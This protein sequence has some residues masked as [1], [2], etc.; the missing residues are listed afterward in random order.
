MKDKLLLV[1]ILITVFFL[2]I[3]VGVAIYIFYNPTYDQSKL[4]F[5]KNLPIASRFFSRNVMFL[6]TSGTEYQIGDEIPVR[7]LV[8]VGDSSNLFVTKIKFDNQ[9]L[10]MTRIDTEE[11]FIKLWVER[12]IGEDEIS[13]VGGVVN[14][15]YVTKAEGELMATVYFKAISLGKPRVILDNKSAI[16]RNADNVN[17][18]EAQESLTLIVTGK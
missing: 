18:L 3:A 8:K 17:I 14:P 4:R 6:S 11:T 1:I 5:I 9:I 7:I 12:Y 10:D 2:L 15:G 16:F 13:L